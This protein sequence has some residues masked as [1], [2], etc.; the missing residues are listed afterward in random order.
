MTAKKIDIPEVTASAL[1]ESDAGTIR[2]K[3]NTDE[4]KYVDLSV[5]NN[6]HFLVE[7]DVT[8]FYQIVKGST[9]A[10]AL[11]QTAANGGSDGPGNGA[12]LA[13]KLTHNNASLW[14]YPN[15]GGAYGNF[16]IGNGGSTGITID[17]SRDAT[18]VA[19][20]ATNGAATLGDASDDAHTVNGTLALASE[21]STGPSAPAAGAG[22]IVYVKDDGKLYF[23][24]DDVAETDLTSG[25]GGAGLT[26]VSK[27]NT[28]SPYTAAAGQFVEITSG[29]FTLN[30]PAAT[31]AGD[32][33]DV[34][35]KDALAN[36]VTISPDGSDT[37][38][39]S[40]ADL[41]VSGNA[42]VNYTF[43]SSGSNNWFIR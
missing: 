8:T 41:R 37:I 34:F 7:N 12:G 23:I 14:L 27:S 19:N 42:R 1:L 5:T 11:F 31:T 25:G 9:T 15:N 4:S 20:L 36:A 28:D 10:G 30:L 39:Y 21:H 13:I 6:E 33:I 17:S 40:S 2:L 18:F 3:D 35:I 32:V 43:V 38:N 26:I 29:P 24:S 16:T 22:G